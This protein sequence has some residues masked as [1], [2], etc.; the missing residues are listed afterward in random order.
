MGIEEWGWKEGGR[1]RKAKNI[2]PIFVK[3]IIIIISSPSSSSSS[4]IRL[5]DTTI[6]FYRLPYLF[7]CRLNIVIIITL[8]VG[9]P[10][11]LC[12]V[13]I[14]IC[15]CMYCTL[16]IYVFILL[17]TQIKYIS[18]NIKRIL[19]CLMTFQQYLGWRIVFV[20]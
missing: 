10:C 1:T 6:K 19:L 14:R 17:Y 15:V 8:I 7:K 18:L 20:E 4:T 5:Y 16:C 13:I 9:V 2:Y 3:F 12:F 11:I